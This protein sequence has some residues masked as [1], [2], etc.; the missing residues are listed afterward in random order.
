MDGSGDRLCG[1]KAEAAEAGR[2]RM[3]G[4][5]SIDR[6]LHD[7]RRLRARGVRSRAMRSECLLVRTRRCVGNDR[8]VDLHQRLRGSLRL[9]HE[10]SRI[11]IGVPAQL[12]QQGRCGRSFRV[13]GP[14]N[15]FFSSSAE[16]AVGGRRRVHRRG[17]VA[18]TLHF[19]C[20]LRNRFLR[21]HGLHAERLLLRT[22][23]RRSRP[24]DL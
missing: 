24:V 7:E 21:L 18:R 15:R 5:G 23:R 17:S 16:A 8:P 22:P 11:E 3:P 14:G 20:G 1:P 13:D 9:G 2:S 12:P 10:R 19:R 6:R 4:P